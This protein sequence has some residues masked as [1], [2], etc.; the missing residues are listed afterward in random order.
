MNR[1]GG[2]RARIASGFLAVPGIYD[3]FSAR[4][5]ESLGFSAVYLPGNALALHLGTGQPL[6]TLTETVDAARRIAAA[7]AIPLIVDAGGG[8]GAGIHVHRSVRE[9]EAAGAAAIH[10]DDQPYPKRAAY[11]LGGGGV[12]SAEEMVARLAVARAARRDPD[13]LLIA[14]S[15][16]LKV[17][18]KLGEMI[19]RARRYVE[20]G[21]DALMILNLPFDQIA[22]IRECVPRVPLIWFATPSDTPPPAAALAEAGFG[23]GLY[24]F[25]TFA[26]VAEAIRTTWC[27]YAEQGTPRGSQSSIR[28]VAKRVQDIVGMPAFHNIEADETSRGS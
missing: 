21:A 17:T 2:L 26:A 19:D 5:I 24:P 18:G 10:L 15:D 1:G 6:V 16:A 25:E 27:D 9:L 20:A 7:I 3:P 13:L 14:R 28:V 22:A 12:A 23:L 4:T 8:F 11:H